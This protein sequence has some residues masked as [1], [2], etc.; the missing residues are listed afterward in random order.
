MD[1]K[2]LERAVEHMTN[3]HF[4]TQHVATSTDIGGG[5]LDLVFTN[6]NH[7]AQSYHTLELLHSTSDYFVVEINIP[8]LSTNNDQEEEKPQF[9]SPFDSLNFL[10]N[11]IDWD[12]VIEDTAVNLR[13]GCKP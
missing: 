7:I 12:K 11:V 6:N 9:A 8:I 4:L 5:V 10:S 2:L 13:N 3:E 1:K